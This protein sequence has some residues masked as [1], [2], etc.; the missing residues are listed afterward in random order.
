[1]ENQRYQRVFP[2]PVI[3]TVFIEADRADG[4]STST[5]RHIDE[6]NAIGKFWA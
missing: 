4:V 3:Y 2:S 1:M 6:S 5:S